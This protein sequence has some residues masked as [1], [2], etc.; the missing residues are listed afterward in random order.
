ME[1]PTLDI[2]GG[3]EADVIRASHRG[4]RK[5]RADESFD[6]DEVEKQQ[7][8]SKEP[9]EA[10]AT[11]A[12]AVSGWFKG[13][14][15]YIKSKAAAATTEA[16]EQPEED[17]E[18]ARERRRARRERR[19]KRR[20]AREAGMATDADATDVEGRTKRRGEVTDMETEVEDRPKK[21]S[22]R[23]KEE[24]P[25]SPV[26]DR[27]SRSRRVKEERSVSPAEEEP[28]RRRRQDKFRPASP[29]EEPS[30][31]R[32]EPSS[33][34]ESRSAP[35]DELTSPVD[36][37]ASRRSRSRQEAR[38]VPTEEDPTSPSSPP[39]RLPIRQRALSI[40]ASVDAGLRGLRDSVAK[41]VANRV[42]ATN[43]QVEADRQEQE[44]RT[45][46]S[47]G[48][49][50]R[51]GRRRG[52]EMDAEEELSRRRG[53]EEDRSMR[54]RGDGANT[55]VE[56]ADPSSRS[57][58]RAASV[59]VTDGEES[60]ASTRSQRRRKQRSDSEGDTPAHRLAKANASVNSTT[61]RPEEIASRAR[62]VI[63]PSPSSNHPRSVREE[64][65]LKAQAARASPVSSTSR[66][67]RLLHDVERAVEAI[68]HVEPHKSREKGRS[69]RAR[70]RR[71][72]SSSDEEAPQ[73]PRRQAAPAGPPSRAPRDAPSPNS[74]RPSPTVGYQAFRAPLLRRWTTSKRP[75][76][77]PPSR[78]N[79][80]LPST[81]AIGLPHLLSPVPSPSPSCLVNRSLPTLRFP[82][83]SARRLCVEWS[84]PR[85]TRAH[86]PFACLVRSASR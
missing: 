2:P 44:H 53:E 17:E 73:H 74:A 9:K 6:P 46:K 85:S 1:D 36:D 78:I 4:L 38:P 57:R 42:E 23:D 41:A 62:Q 45:V 29:V 39:A 21:P 18:E 60:D 32:Q 64:L 26:E 67:S 5:T 8:E 14:G 65:R 15:D 33:P 82:W 75:E 76:L 79:P 48:R 80:C 84:S 12:A 50:S 58:R 55:D 66:S 43:A 63:P 7:K 25:S 3:G 51:S 37:R 28:P 20:E 11:T 19:R 31:R 71:Y 35:R 47:Q 24:E 68:E 40:S 13:V 34:T 10:P 27:P 86:S 70:S 72:S 61:I 69:S 83:T 22:R 54:R 77:L 56:D 81:P 16:Q 30:R 49:A 59:A 52:G